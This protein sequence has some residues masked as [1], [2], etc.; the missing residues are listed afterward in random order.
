MVD[1]VKDQAQA[2]PEVPATSGETG[3]KS[4]EQLSVEL[5]AVNDKLAAEEKRIR[6]KDAHISKL[7]QEARDRKEAEEETLSSKSSE[8]DGKLPQAIL[9]IKDEQIREKAKKFYKNGNGME[10]VNAVYNAELLVNEAREKVQND[11]L[12]LI[13]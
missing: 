11:T 7:E 2:Q 10:A 3:I 1:E 5:K 6:D 8:E 12:E 13:E 4:A 9:D